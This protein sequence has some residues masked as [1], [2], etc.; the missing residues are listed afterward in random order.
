M[1]KIATRNGKDDE[2]PP[3]EKTARKQKQDQPVAQP[4]RVAARAHRFISSSTCVG[5]K[6]SADLVMLVS[7]GYGGLVQTAA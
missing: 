3:G 7:I 4:Q 6:H 5:S 2:V 1:G